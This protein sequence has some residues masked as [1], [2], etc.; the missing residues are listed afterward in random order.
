MS[1]M[2]EWGDSL[3]AMSDSDLEDIEDSIET[4]NRWGLFS[5][6]YPE[7]RTIR[8]IV[9]FEGKQRITKAL[10]C[11]HKRYRIVHNIKT[12]VHREGFQTI[13]VCEDCGATVPMGGSKWMK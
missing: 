9:E 2:E 7:M 3:K 5:M 13:K 4:L 8:K 10:S 6:N 1:S 11:N 12:M